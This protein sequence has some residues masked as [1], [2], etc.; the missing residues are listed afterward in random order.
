[1]RWP[2]SDGKPLGRDSDHD[3]ARERMTLK[4]NSRLE[5]VAEQLDE[6]IDQVSEALTRRFEDVQGGR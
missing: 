3:R 4:L 1:M 2:W 6:A 5:V